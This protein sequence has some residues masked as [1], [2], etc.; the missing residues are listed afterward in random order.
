MT[1]RTGD[2]LKSSDQQLEDAAH[3]LDASDDA[4]GNKRG[5]NIDS[6][7]CEFGRGVRGES[8]CQG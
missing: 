1:A 2:T 7:R 4:G 6:F 8:R 5:A 3:S